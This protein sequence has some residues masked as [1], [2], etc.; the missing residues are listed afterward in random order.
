[1]I[2]FGQS[3]S[4]SPYAST[5]DDPNHL[6]EQTPPQHL[7]ADD[8]RPGPDRPVH[9]AYPSR[10]RERQSQGEFRHR[11]AVDPR[12]VAHHHPARLGGGEVDVVDPV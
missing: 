7:T 8:P 4:P 9:F 5:V 10:D 2:R 6:P 1:M 12:R 3:N 11:L